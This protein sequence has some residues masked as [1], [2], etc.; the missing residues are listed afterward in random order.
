MIDASVMHFLTKAKAYAAL[1]GAM[2]TGLIALGAIPLPD[3]CV[4]AAAVLTW[5]G[6]WAVPN[7]ASVEPY[8]GAHE[9][10]NGDLGTVA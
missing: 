6:V 5:F 2:L 3:W 8:V 10:V 7:A 4:A 1:V 9:A